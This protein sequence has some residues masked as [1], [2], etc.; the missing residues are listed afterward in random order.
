MNKQKQNTNN[1]SIQVG[2][3]AVIEGVMMRS[4]DRVAT[5][6]RRK[7]GSITKQEEEKVPFTVRHPSW[8]IPIVRGFIALV[9][10][11]T[12]GIKTLNFSA[13]IAVEDDEEAQRKKAEAE[14]KRF[15]EKKQKSKGASALGTALTLLVA[16]GIA[17]LLFFVTPLFAAT[18]LFDVEQN[19]LGFNLVSGAFRVGILLGYLY[20]ISRLKEYSVYFNITAPSIRQFMHLKKI[21]I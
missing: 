9:E 19:A 14:G 21:S 17:L 6:V 1:P 16:F 15:K 10:M 7:D 13:D 11:M 2:G 4:P 8:N 3:Q 5:A 12:I 20:I 18:A